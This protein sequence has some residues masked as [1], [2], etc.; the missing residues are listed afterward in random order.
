MLK[1]KSLVVAALLDD[2]VQ[3]RG[4]IDAAIW[5]DGIGN[6]GADGTEG[7]K[8]FGAGPLSVRLLQIAGGDVVDDDI[9]AD[10]RA[11]HLHRR[12]AC[13]RRGR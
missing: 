10:V 6:N 13:G 8:A 2:A 4:D 1:I 3:P 7:I 9:A 5:I 11:V 12:A